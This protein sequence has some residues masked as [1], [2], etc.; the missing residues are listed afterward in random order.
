MVLVYNNRTMCHACS[1]SL[2]IEIKP[3]KNKE[4]GESVP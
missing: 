2:Y 4:D 3:K 1:I